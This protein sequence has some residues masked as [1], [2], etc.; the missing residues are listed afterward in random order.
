MKPYYGEDDKDDSKLVSEDEPEIRA[1]YDALLSNC[2]LDNSRFRLKKFNLI[3]ILANFIC[4]ASAWNHHLHSAVSFEYSVDPN[5]TGLKIL[6]NNATQNNIQNYAE[7]CCVALSKGWQHSD[8]ME[9]DVWL[10][11]LESMPKA[12]QKD[13]SAKEFTAYFEGQ[14]QTMAHKIRERNKHRTVP[15]NAMNPSNCQS[16]A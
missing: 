3:N 13:L 15:Y 10:R 11:A 2:G 16:S 12:H 7:Y 1:F 4:S 5:F 14:M 9:K 8:L 6:G